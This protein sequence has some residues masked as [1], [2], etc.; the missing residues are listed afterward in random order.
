MNTSS[1]WRISSEATQKPTLPLSKEGI[2]RSQVLIKI[3]SSTAPGSQQH[4]V[5]IIIRSS[6][7][8][9]PQQHQVL[10]ILLVISKEAN[11]HQVIWH[12][13]YLGNLHTIIGSSLMQHQHP[14]DIATVS[15]WC[16]NNIHNARQHYPHGALSRHCPQC[17]SSTLHSF[18]ALTRH[19][20]WVLR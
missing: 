11:S 15:T 3:T 10:I 18:G 7:S 8:S 16:N 12:L 2:L 1:I 6:T 20:Q 9:G 19:P 4:Q 14:H 5:L 13:Q 17:T